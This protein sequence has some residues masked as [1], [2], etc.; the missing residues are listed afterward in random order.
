M[1]SNLVY[2]YTCN[3]FEFRLDIFQLFSSCMWLVAAISDCE[4]LV[5]PFV[6]IKNTKILWIS[7]LPL[8][9][10]LCNHTQVKLSRS[11]FI[12]CNTEIKIISIPLSCH[13]G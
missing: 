12:I 10:S 4:G 6:G 5:V 9:W 11:S 2:F 7:I 8:S 13:E 1:S 3:T